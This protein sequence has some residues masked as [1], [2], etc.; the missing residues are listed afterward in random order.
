MFD[1]LSPG[2]QEQSLVAVLDSILT[3][4]EENQ[5]E[6]LQEWFTSWKQGDV[7]A[8]AKSFQAMEGESSE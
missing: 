2:A 3:P 8:F 7:E 1:A 4:S 5:S 6:M